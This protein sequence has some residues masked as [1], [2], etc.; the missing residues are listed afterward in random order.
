MGLVN[1]AYTNYS[2]VLRSLCRVAAIVVVVTVFTS[3]PQFC[4]AGIMPGTPGMLAFDFINGGPTELNNEIAVKDIVVSGMFGVGPSPNFFNQKDKSVFPDFE[5]ALSVTYGTNISFFFKPLTSVFES[6]DPDTFSFFL[7]DG[8]GTT[9]LFSSD[10]PG[11]TNALFV[12]EITGAPGGNL[13]VHSDT[14]S[15]PITTWSVIPSPP[16]GDGFYLVNIRTG[17][18]NSGGGEIPEPASVVLWSFMAAGA[19]FCSRKRFR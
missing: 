17:Q 5:V 16:D 13:I 2:H 14:D 19:A 11:G 8:L 6:P 12:L 7:L 1:Y 3:A 10:A 4:A 15:D 18:A 9:S